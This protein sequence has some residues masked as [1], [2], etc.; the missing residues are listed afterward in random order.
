MALIGTA[1]AMCLKLCPLRRCLLPAR[2]TCL[3]HYAA[4]TGETWRKIQRRLYSYHRQHMSTQRTRYRRR[5]KANLKDIFVSPYPTLFYWYGSVNV[6][7]KTRLMRPLKKRHR[8][9]QVKSI[10]ECSQGAFCNIFDLHLA[11]ICL[12][13]LWVYL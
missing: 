5:Y 8:I 10:A 3:F 13:D 9:M 7:S 1:S 12:N 4:K 11:P 6:Y 2:N